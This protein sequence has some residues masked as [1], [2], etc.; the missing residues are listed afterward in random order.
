MAAWNST[1]GGQRRQR[2]PSIAGQPSAGHIQHDTRRSQTRPAT[3]VVHKIA[4]NYTRRSD[5]M[6]GLESSDNYRV[7]NSI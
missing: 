5:V 2:S 6:K 4:V 7:L 3:T 1:S